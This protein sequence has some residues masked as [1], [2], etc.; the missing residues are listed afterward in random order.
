MIRTGIVNRIM[1]FV[2]SPVK[3][4]SLWTSNREARQSDLNPKIRLYLSQNSNRNSSIRG[5]TINNAITHSYP[6]HQTIIWTGLRKFNASLFFLD[7]SCVLN[8]I[9][10]ALK[11]SGKAIWDGDISFWAVTM[12]F[13]IGHFLFLGFVKLQECCLYQTEISLYIPCWPDE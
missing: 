8:R 2:L 5:T 12:I 4:N 1:S 7:K 6:L 13:N 3:N 11:E 10:N 9:K